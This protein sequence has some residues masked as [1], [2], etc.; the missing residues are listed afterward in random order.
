M[1]YDGVI[2]DLDGVLI[3]TDELHYIAWKTIADQIG[4]PFS[5]E[6]NNRLRG[7]SRMDSLDIILSSSGEAYSDMEKELLAEEKNQ[8]YRNLLEKL[9][10]SD[11][12]RGV[13]D[14]LSYLKTKGY[15]IAIGSSSK[16]AEMILK[17]T[18][19]YDY[20]DAI[21][22]GNNISNSKPDPE[23]FLKAAS[24]LMLSPS[25]CV[26]VEDA[27]AGVDAA[28]AG[29]FFCFGIGDASNHEAIYGAINSLTDL[30]AYL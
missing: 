28:I 12:D 9:N 4:I 11:L 22:D 16:N 23:V 5:R 29:G 6:I 25:N 15:K 13:I 10:P 2:F 27:K 19:L 24:F 21:S 26:V 8:I 30:K 14:I 20:F 18:K 7:V 17:S 1:K 3:H